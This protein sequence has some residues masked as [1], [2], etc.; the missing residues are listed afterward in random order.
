MTYKLWWER[1]NDVD[2]IRRQYHINNASIKKT[3][4]SY[5]SI[6]H[7]EYDGPLEKVFFHEEYDGPLE[8]VDEYWKIDE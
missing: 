6:F 5:Y 8:K 1:E 7:Q 4:H 2:F 3:F